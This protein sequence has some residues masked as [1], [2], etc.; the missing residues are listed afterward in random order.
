MSVLTIYILTYILDLTVEVH[1]Y[2]IYLPSSYPSQK[3]RD[4]ISGLSVDDCKTYCKDKVRFCIGISH[5][6]IKSDGS[7]K[8]YFYDKFDKG[9]EPKTHVDTDTWVTW[10]DTAFQSGTFLSDA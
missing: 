8:C 1:Q 7:K 10:L 3:L 9:L 5:Q 2:Q 4:P 6:T